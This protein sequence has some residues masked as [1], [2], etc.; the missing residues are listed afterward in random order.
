MARAGYR[1]AEAS[2]LSKA[3]IFALAESVAKQ[4][5]FEPGDDIHEFVERVGGSVLVEDTLTEDPERSGSLYV[6]SPNKF[7]I[8]VPAHTSLVRDRFTVAHEFGHFIVHYMWPLQRGISDSSPMMA[9]R[10]GSDRIEWEA[11][12]FAAAFLMPKKAFAKS[13]KS[14]GVGGAATTFGVS[15]AAADVRARQLGLA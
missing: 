2:N 5:E 15:Q 14:S 13:F 4:L 10:K 8:I 6:D 11:N 9:L 3:Q 12:W 7:T 1:R